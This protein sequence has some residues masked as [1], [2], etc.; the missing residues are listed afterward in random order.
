MRLGVDFGSK[1]NQDAAI[2][3]FERALAIDPELVPAMVGLARTLVHRVTTLYSDDP[4]G[5]IARAEDWAGRAVVAEPDNSDAH[6]AKANVFFAKREWAQA[7][8]E[9]ETAIAANPNNADAQAEHTFWKMFVGRSEDGFSGVETAFR[10]S[11]RDPGVPGWQFYV[12]HLHTHLA[13]WEQAIEWCNKAIAAGPWM[14]PLVDLA[15]ANAF[16][17]HEK[18]AKEAVAQLRKVNPGF[19]VQTWAGIHWTDDP[20]FNAQY[21]RIVDGL[22]KAGLPEGEKKTD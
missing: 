2:G 10:L 11:P 12:C 8:P 17:G 19:T 4:K 22:R 20:T 15:A 14:Y 7:I 6:N 3:L 16:A 1:A 5:D 13:Q 9:A 21:A 18:E